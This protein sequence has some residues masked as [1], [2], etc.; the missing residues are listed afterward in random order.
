MSVRMLA[1]LL[2]LLAFTTLT[3][4]QSLHKDERLG[5]QFK[6][7]RGFKSIA[8]TPNERL[9]IAKYQDE[10]PLYI[11]SNGFQQFFN[12]MNLMLFKGGLR[13]DDD[14]TRPLDE[15]IESF[16]E[17]HFGEH[18]LKRL[19][20]TK[21]ARAEACEA[22]V[23]LPFASPEPMGAYL[24]AI[25]QPEGTFLFVGETIGK[26]LSKL[27]SSFSKA[28]KGFKRVEKSGELSQ[29]DL[30]Q[31]TGQERFLAE[32]VAKLPPGWESLRT[33][34]YLFLFNA[35]KSFVKEMCEQI[36][37]IRDEYERLYPPDAPIEAIS[38]VRVCDSAEDYYG[39]GGP[40]GS[41]GYWSSGAKE[42]VF[43]DMRPR[44]ATLSVL[45]HEAFHQYIYYF[46]GELA[47]HSWYNEGHG[48]Y[49][50]G[51]KLTGTGRVKKYGKAPG[52]FDRSG[53]I[54]EAVRLLSQGKS[55]REGGC[56]NLKDLMRFH[57]SEFYASHRRSVCYAAGWAVVHMLRE[58]RRLDDK[59]EKILPEY[60]D[61]LL[62][63]RHEAAEK[64]RDKAVG[65]WKKQDEDD[66]GEPPSDDP[67]VYYTL[68]STTDVQDRAY[69]LT[70]EE[71]TDDDWADFEE[72][73]IEY[74]S[75]I[76]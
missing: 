28:A 51:A 47:P 54:K 18:D 13:E 3:S 20:S 16:I 11:G 12:S 23:L 64:I 66:R 15:R 43:F 65:D 33:E 55:D 41:G 37:G 67:A 45:R 38:I 44:E 49:F 53:I 56:P 63:A 59:W 57:Q 68:T 30:E 17:D 35:D 10:S 24:C 8:I 74:C 39:Y 34:R 5:Y 6:P 1:S 32:Q 27:K 46:Y 61:F 70:F 48:D 62:Q 2:L 58:S 7:P 75:K 60:L 26:N 72:E 42:L 21:I 22:E 40:R 69:E 14:D 76:G 36:E 31:M 29:S 9:I 73:F 25:E 19:R 50:A 4:A 71:W 52:G